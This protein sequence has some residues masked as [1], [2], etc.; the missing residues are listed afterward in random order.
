MAK[1]IIHFINSV[2]QVVNNDKD[3]GDLLKVVFVEDYN[4]SKAEILFPGADISEHIST[5]GTEASGTSCMKGVLNGGLLIGTCDGANVGGVVVFPTQT[6]NWPQIEITREIG[7]NNIFLF[8][9]LAEDVEDLRHAHSYGQ[10]TID[11]DLQKV[12]DAVNSGMFGDRNAFSAII[13]AITDHG[14]FY[15]VSDDFSSYIKTQ[16]LIDEA[17]KNQE[18]WITKCITSVARMGFFTS[19]RCM[20][21]YAESIWNI[22]PL[23]PAAKA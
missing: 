8:G 9:N 3:V 6:N 15:L 10:H 21:E 16:S 12:F 4:V 11:K 23:P 22:E 17:Y 20:Q 18:E 2:G 14:D 5:S 13:S 7:E 19:D 1:N